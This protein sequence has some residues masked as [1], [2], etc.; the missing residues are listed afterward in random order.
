MS[1]GYQQHFTS[2]NIALLDRILDRA[3]MRDMSDSAGRERRLNAARFLIEKFQDG[4]T[5]EG[6]LYFALVN[7]PGNLKEEAAHVSDLPDSDASVRGRSRPLVATQD[8]YRFGRRIEQNGTWTVYHV[9]SGEPAV[10]GSWNMV[11]LNVR[12]AERALRILNAPVQAA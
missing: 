4:V 8:G 5:D 9:F 6:A 10:Y 3:D 2:A 12:T 7:R 1:S 11:G